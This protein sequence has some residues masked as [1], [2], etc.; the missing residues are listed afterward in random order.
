MSFSTLI[1]P[2]PPGAD[3]E[4]VYCFLYLAYT[5]ASADGENV[6]D[7]LD[8]S[9]KLPFLDS[10]PAKTYVELPFVILFFATTVPEEVFD[11]T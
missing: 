9:V 7:A 5:S 1:V 11:V 2:L 10:Q 6:V 3:A 4:T 8:A